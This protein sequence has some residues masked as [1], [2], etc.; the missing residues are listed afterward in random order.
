VL[1]HDRHLDVTAS[2]S[3]SRNLLGRRT[4][5]YFRRLGYLDGLIALERLRKI[6]RRRAEHTIFK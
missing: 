1:G 4:L 5:E 6:A 2:K 3:R